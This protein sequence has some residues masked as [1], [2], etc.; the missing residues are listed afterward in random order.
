MHSKTVFDA[1]PQVVG[2]ST[3]SPNALADETVKRCAVAQF[4]E[5]RE[6]RS[7]YGGTIA[8][9]VEFQPRRRGRA[10]PKCAAHHAGVEE[11]D[12]RV[13]AEVAD[14]TGI[15]RPAEIKIGIV[16]AGNHLHFSRTVRLA[17]R[18]GR[19]AFV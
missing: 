8:N 10:Q 6:I 4:E 9:T 13:Y 5:P 18:R 14:A 16:V 15:T 7:N 12:L 3:P 17:G 2:P 19:L 1:A 11:L